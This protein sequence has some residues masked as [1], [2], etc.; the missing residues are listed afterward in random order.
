[1]Y[2]Q[3]YLPAK[4]NSYLRVIPQDLLEARDVT[5]LASIIATIASRN[6]SFAIKVVVYV[7]LL[8]SYIAG[9]IADGIDCDGIIG[10]DSSVSCGGNSGGGSGGGGHYLR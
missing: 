8:A 10:Q 6:A 2:I 5:L 3:I 4:E 7:F 1:M 9:M